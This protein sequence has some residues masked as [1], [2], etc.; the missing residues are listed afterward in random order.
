MKS[1]DIVYTLGYVAL[2]SI[3]LYF[4]FGLLKI[5]GQGLSSMGLTDDII[6]GMTDKAKEKSMGKIDKLIE[7]KQKELEKMQEDFDPDEFSDKISELMDIEK[8]LARHKFIEI[9]A[10]DGAPGAR[11][12]I[13]AITSS[14]PLGV[15]SMAI[16][17]ENI[18]ND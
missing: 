9:L 12:A 16:D 17:P 6:E 14:H 1:K 15:L 18:L 8:K 2:F 4:V 10:K 11:D 5:S 3:A 13:D 7:K